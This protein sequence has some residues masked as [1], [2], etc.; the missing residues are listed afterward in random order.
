MTDKKAKKTTSSTSF[1]TVLLVTTACTLL[2]MLNNGVRSNFGLIS[3]AV[4]AYTGLSESAVSAAVAAAQLLYGLSQPFFGMLALKKS[5]SF[6]LGAGGILMGAGLLLIPFCKSDLLLFVALGVLVGLAAGALAF[7]IVMG[8]A[9]PAIGEKYAAAA[10][11]IINGGGGLGGAVLAPYLQSMTDN[12]MF[13]V[14]MVILSCISGCVVLLCIWLNK[15]ETAS[16]S[17]DVNTQSAPTVREMLREA[18]KSSR[19]L[20]LALAFFTCG[21]FMAIIETY[22]YPQ[23]ISYGFSG[24]KVAFLFT[25]YG[26]MGMI[27]PV[28][29]GFLCGKINPTIV[30]GTTY[31]LRPVLVILFLLLPK[32]EPAVYAFVIG[33]GLVGNATVPP[34]TLLI[35]R[36]F[37]SRKMPT[38]SGIAM[39]FHQIGSALSTALG[40]VLIQQKYGYNIIWLCGAAVALIAAILCYTVKGNNVPVLRTQHGSEK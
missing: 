15:K 25:V 21:F 39:V 24:S 28:I 37:G 8:A 14:G 30:L 3:S 20:H 31:A 13:P 18:F 16:I 6:V 40:G 4:T 17:E 23:L 27:G 2:F 11:G 34:T 5:N 9:S 7:G 26:I 10:S 33:L 32:S 35:E 29:S 38:L 36:F 19:F 1:A 12:N 22:L